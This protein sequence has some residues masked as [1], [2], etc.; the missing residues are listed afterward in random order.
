RAER[1]LSAARPVSRAASRSATKRTG[2]D[3]EHCFFS[4]GRSLKV[5]F[6]ALDL[7][8][9]HVAMNRHDGFQTVVLQLWLFLPVS[10]R[11]SR[12][13]ALRFDR[14]TT[15]INFRP[16]SVR[17][18]INR[19]SA[20]H[21]RSRGKKRLRQPQVGN[22]SSSSWRWCWRKRQDEDLVRSVN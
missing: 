1:A 3:K 4:S 11:E 5:R 14:G 12:R 9:R 2:R 15:V 6:Q 16:Q 21:P 13:L 7:A 20:D 22:G 8:V 19:D 10:A 18:V 17:A